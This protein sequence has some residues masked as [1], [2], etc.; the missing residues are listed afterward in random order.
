MQRIMLKSKIHRATVTDSNL[1]YEGSVAIDEGLMETAG[2][3]PFE[4][5]EIYNITNGSRLTTYAI[6]GERGS[7]TI[8]INGAAAHLA[9][10]GDMVIIVSF[11]VVDE[12]EAAGHEPVLVY[13]D[14]RNEVKKV[15][16]K[17]AGYV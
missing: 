8:S 4:Q 2:I 17:L 16:G 13:V 7:G 3:Y 12:P 14:E 15:S 1:D 11:S 10:K 9:E 6:K 5:V